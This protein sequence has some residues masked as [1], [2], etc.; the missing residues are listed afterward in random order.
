MTTPLTIYLTHSAH[1]DIGFTHP[2]EQ[3]MRMYVAHY[4]R[5]LTLAQQTATAPPELRF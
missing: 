2:Q 4:D 1:T 3:I 5:V